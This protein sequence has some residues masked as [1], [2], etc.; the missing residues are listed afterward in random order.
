MERSVG[1]PSL[2]ALLDTWINFS[3]GLDRQLYAV[4]VRRV[5]YVLFGI[6]VVLAVSRLARERER[7]AMLFCLMY[8]GVPLLTAWLLSQAKPMYT[9]RYLLPFLPPYCIVG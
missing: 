4:L 9:I 2:R 7:E 8:I 3:V 5:A 1:Q 6:C